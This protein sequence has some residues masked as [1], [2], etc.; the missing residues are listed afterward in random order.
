MPINGRVLSITGRQ[1]ESDVIVADLRSAQK[2]CQDG[3][4]GDAKPTF[5]QIALHAVDVVGAIAEALMNLL[6]CRSF[7]E[8]LILVNCTGDLDGVML[9]CAALDT[10]KT[11]ELVRKEEQLDKSSFLDKLLRSTKKMETFRLSTMMLPDDAACVAD[12]IEHSTTS[13]T[14]LELR[15]STFKPGSAVELARGLKAN[16][17]LK[18]LDFCCC[19]LDD[20]Q[21][22]DVSES[23]IGHPNLETLSF[24][25]NNCGDLA[26]RQLASQLTH[27][28]CRLHKLDLSFQLRDD[29]NQT[30]LD[31]RNILSAL[32]KNQSLR[33]LD[34]TCNRLNDDDATMIA[35]VLK[36]NTTLEEVILSRNQFTDVGI[37]N[38]AEQLPHMKGLKKLSL[39]GNMFTEDGAMALLAGLALNMGLHTVNLFQHFKC[40]KQIQY[41]CNINRGGRKLLQ[42]SPSNVPLGLWPLAFE[43]ANRINLVK[44]KEEIADEASRRADMLFCLLRGPVLVSLGNH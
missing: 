19:C 1:T 12:G 28:R 27:P 37:K 21:M 35:Q 8:S 3:G 43:R 33:V 30:K 20:Q 42:E 26:G 7:W 10:V 32:S 17:S 2:K 41:F 15:W 24:Q 38:I 29:Q 23:L 44:R 14:S 16:Q 25:S 13:L 34:L 39:W 11:I 9:R 18:Y 40:S 36:E 6:G 22:A 5:D 31:V 4:G